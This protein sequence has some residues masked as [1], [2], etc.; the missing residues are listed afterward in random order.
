MDKSDTYNGSSSNI[1]FFFVQE[2]HQT[3]H[4]FEFFYIQTIEEIDKIMEKIKV[5][6]RERERERESKDKRQIR[7][8]IK[9]EVDVDLSDGGRG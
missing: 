9:R 4:F 7:K 8:E 1:S 2:F 3:K 5:R 6:E